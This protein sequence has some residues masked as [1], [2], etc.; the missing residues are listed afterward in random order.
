[1]PPEGRPKCGSDSGGSGSFVWEFAH[2]GRLFARLERKLRGWGPHLDPAIGSERGL[3]R[4]QQ[5]S[6]REAASETFKSFDVSG[7]AADWKVR[8]PAR[9]EVSSKAHRRWTRSAAWP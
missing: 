1:M 6:N 2:P 3:S 7:V 9:L 5:C 4:P 8:A